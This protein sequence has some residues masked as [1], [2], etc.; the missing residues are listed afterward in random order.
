MHLATLISLSSLGFIASSSAQSTWKKHAVHEGFHTNT[1]VGGDFTG[2][3]KPDI[4]ANNDNK[5]RLFVAPD[6][7]ETII[8]TFDGNKFI[9][10]ESFDVDS[11]GD[12]D[13]IGARYQPGLIVWLENPGKDTGQPWTRRTISRELNGIHGLL[14]GDVNKDG[15]MDLLANSA[16]LVGT[17]HPVSLAWFEIPDQQQ[18]AAFW[19]VHIF[20]KG[21]APG[22]S[23]YFGFGDVNGDG[24]P[25]AATGAKG[26]PS[27]DGNYFAWWQ[28]PKDPTKAWTKH[29]LAHDQV[30]ATNIHPADVNGDGKT[31][32]I[33]SRGHGR[34]VIWLEAPDWQIHAIHE[35]LKEPHAMIALDMDD[36]GDVD[37]AACAFGD[38]QAYWFENDGKGSF[39]NHLIAENQ[40]A[41]DIRALDMDIDQ[42]IDILIAGRGSKNVVWYE[43]PKSH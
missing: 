11:D 43:N 34:G 1:V 24:M 37:A 16:Q 6:W 14:K 33:A 4:I 27:T 2:D 30:G 29:V 25:D 19:P 18:Q 23:H 15:K 38:A 5:T 13:F 21:D 42:D 12:L 28:A 35:T 22:L 39:T 31:D 36:D 8:D 40:E 3:G 7:K 20:A 41:Y 10:A 32:F 9:H 17:R 26:R